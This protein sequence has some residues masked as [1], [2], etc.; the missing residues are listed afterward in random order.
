[1][2][3]RRGPSEARDTYQPTGDEAVGVGEQTTERNMKIT[4]TSGTEAIVWI[5]GNSLAEILVR[6]GII[7]R[8]AVE[9][10]EG[11]DGGETMR[12]VGTAAK[13]ISEQVKL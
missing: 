5:S 12:H 3:S 1:M 6:H 10:P 7:D 2:E 13:E 4:E 9:D 11:Y 8:C